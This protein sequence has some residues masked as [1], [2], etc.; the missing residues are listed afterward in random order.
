MASLLLR[1]RESNS[2]C[3]QSSFESLKFSMEDFHFFSN[4]FY[5]LIDLTFLQEKLFL[6]YNWTGK[7]GKKLFKYSWQE[8]TF[9]VSI[10]HK[11]YVTKINK[12]WGKIFYSSFYSGK[13]KGNNNITVIR[14]IY[15]CKTNFMYLN[16]AVLR[17]RIFYCNI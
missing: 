17:G 2:D 3:I 8:N 11:S 12:K 15:K 6:Y 1:I 10:F 13:K 5:L 4:N 16:L 9:L 14:H 7:R